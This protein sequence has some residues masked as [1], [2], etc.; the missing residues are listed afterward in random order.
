MAGSVSGAEE[1]NRFGVAACIACQVGEALEDVGNDEVGM[2]VGSDHE[3]LMKVA[4]GRFDFI[5]RD[6]NPRSCG[7]RRRRHCQLEPT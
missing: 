5:L 1:P 7:Q 6:L 4:L 3:C 2:H